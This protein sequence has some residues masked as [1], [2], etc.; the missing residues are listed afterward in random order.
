MAT[1][2]TLSSGSSSTLQR[3]PQAPT[4]ASRGTDNRAVGDRQSQVQSQGSE[5][6][7]A[8][9]AEQTERQDQAFRID[10]RPQGAE[11]RA[12]SARTEQ[13]EPAQPENEARAPQGNPV[14]VN[15]NASGSVSSSFNP[16]QPGRN[17]SLTV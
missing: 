8:R 16:N 7:E 1:I 14:P 15:F 10:I 9:R 11:A 2:D 6:G 12:R 3:P 13:Q 4:E 17:I 5:Q